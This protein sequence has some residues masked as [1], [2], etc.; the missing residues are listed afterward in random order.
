MTNSSLRLH[1]T[2]W[3]F[4][5]AYT[6]S[7]ISWRIPSSLPDFLLNG[8]LVGKDAGSEA[9]KEEVLQKSKIDV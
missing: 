1:S 4:L 2:F 7:V 3:L 8:S 5:A 9:T 6:Q